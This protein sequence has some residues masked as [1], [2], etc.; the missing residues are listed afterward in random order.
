MKV[1][2]AGKMDETLERILRQNVRVPD[3]VMG[4]LYA[5]FTGLRAHGDSMSLGLMDEH[6]LESLEELSRELHGRT[7]SAM[8]K[9]IR[10]V[11]DGTYHAEAVSDGIDKPIRLKMA[12][13]VN[14]DEIDIDFAGSDAQVQKSINVCLAYTTAYT[15]YGV[16]AVLCPDV[17]EQR[18]RARPPHRDGAARLHPELAAARGRWCPCPDRPLPAGD[19][20]QR[21]RESRAGQGDRGRGLAAVVR[22]HGRRRSRTAAASP[23][24]SS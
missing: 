9:A 2:S 1:L 4:D 12:L 10:E 15:S 13:T 3:Q 5:Q 14:G 19:G 18:R 7:E 20:A 24:C 21:P 22:E 23:T 11:P 6:G 17:P 16:K 8:R